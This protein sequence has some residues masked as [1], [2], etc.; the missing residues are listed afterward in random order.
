M[1]TLVDANP[2]IYVGAV[3]LKRPPKGCKVIYR[4]GA[5]YYNSKERKRKGFNKKIIQ[6]INAADFVVFQSA[7]SKRCVKKILRLKP[8][9]SCIIYNGFDSSA[10]PITS[11]YSSNKK[12]FVA[13]SNWKLDAKRG[14][15]IVDFFLKADVDNSELIMIGPNFNP[16]WRSYGERVKCTDSLKTEQI[17]YYL[18][19]KPI[20]I[21][22][23]YA[24]ACPNVIIEALS[25]GCPVITNNIGASPEI[26]KND[27]IIAKCDREFRF[28]MK[29]T[30]T[31]AIKPEAVVTAIRMS[32][33]QKWSISRPDLSMESCAKMYLDTFKGVLAN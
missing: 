30:D 3:F 25:F 2:D 21:H 28:R 17:N 20:F 12:T 33:D 27:G 22:L 26:V 16:K 6:S 32:V 9:N 5:V 8:K 29:S 31:N 14:D 13:C 19:S 23:C 15:L 24:E 4:C 11:I 18:A 7:F 1:I 10:Y